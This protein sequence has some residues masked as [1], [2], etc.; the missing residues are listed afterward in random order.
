[1]LKNPP[2]TSYGAAWSSPPMLAAGMSVEEVWN[3]R[4]ISGKNFPPAFPSSSPFTFH[5]D[6]GS[7]SSHM[8]VTASELAVVMR[9]DDPQRS[10]RPV[11]TTGDRARLAVLVSC[12]LYFTPGK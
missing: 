6:I 3:V 4:R 12:A 10:F 8:V 2:H 9:V 5:L 7:T 11:R 1:M